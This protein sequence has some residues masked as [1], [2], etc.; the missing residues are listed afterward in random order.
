MA[1]IAG[2]SLGPL[3][4]LVISYMLERSARGWIFAVGGIGA[5][6]LPWITGLLSTH[7]NSLRYGL[8]APC[9]VGLLMAV[10]QIVALW[11]PGP[12]QNAAATHL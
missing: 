5:A 3:Y 6:I 12:S 11:Q 7:F 4:P 9:A 1:G 10:L 2:L 8:I